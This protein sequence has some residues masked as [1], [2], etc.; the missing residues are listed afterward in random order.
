MVLHPAD[1]QNYLNIYR[2]KGFPEIKIA[3]G[4]FHKLQEGRRTKLRLF[5]ALC[6]LVFLCPRPKKVAFHLII[7]TATLL[8]LS[9]DNQTK[10]ALGTTISSCFD[11]SVRLS[12]RTHCALWARWRSCCLLWILSLSWSSPSGPAWQHCELWCTVTSLP[13]HRCF[14]RD[15]HLLFL[16]TRLGAANAR[17]A[18]NCSWT[19][20]KSREACHNQTEELFEL[21]PPAIPSWALD[22]GIRCHLLGRPVLISIFRWFWLLQL[23]PCCLEEPACRFRARGWV[24]RRYSGEREK[25]GV[26]HLRNRN[27]TFSRPPWIFVSLGRWD[28]VCF[29]LSTSLQGFYCESLLYSL[30]QWP[31]GKTWQPW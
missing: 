4:V 21:K 3:E 11:H 2:G 8:L 24:G 18:G 28:Q 12:F 25:E 1:S 17:P 15:Q 22:I 7:D 26:S 31:V 27:P 30:C 29:L 16:K 9:S 14:W 5:P 23:S 19:G 13:P 6:V 20:N 10:Q